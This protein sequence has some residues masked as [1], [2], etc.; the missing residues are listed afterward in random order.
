VVTLST[1]N[2]VGAT[3]TISLNVSASSGIPPVSTST[4]VTDSSGT[5]GIS[6]GLYYYVSHT[7]GDS[8][9]VK[10]SAQFG[11][12]PVSNTTGRLITDGGTTSKLVVV[13]GPVSQTAGTTASSLSPFTLERRDDFDNPTGQATV[14]VILDDTANGQVAVHAGRGFSPSNHDFEFETP[15]VGT[16]ISGFSY[17]AAETQKTFV[18]FDKM[19]STP[20]EDGRTGAWTLQAYVGTTFVN[21]NI[22]TQYN[23]IVN[24]GITAKLNFHNPIR[25]LQAGFP[26]NLTG[27]LNLSALNV[28]LQDFNGNPTVT[29]S[30]VTVQL[31]TSR[32]PSSAFDGYG[33]SVSTAIIGEP[34]PPAPDSKARPPP[35]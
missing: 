33:F 23:L 19:T 29:P 34:P 28:E 12:L 35:S 15:G 4:V 17:G 30:S 13:S 10:F 5:V 20:L 25:T 16:P 1:F 6:S 22:K 32:L 3:G 14:N 2:V 24:P 11:A 27:N 7:V 8:S 9:Q 21:S 18:Y 31:A 26:L